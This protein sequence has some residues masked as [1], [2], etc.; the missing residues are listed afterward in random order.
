MMLVEPDDVLSAGDIV[1]NGRIPFMG[2]ADVDTENWLRSLQTVTDLKPRFI[3][4]GH[5]RPSTDTG[6][7]IVFTRG[8]ITYLRMRMAKAVQDWADFDTAYRKADWSKY[9]SLPAFN[10][11]N[12]GNAYR[13]FLDMENAAFSPATPAKP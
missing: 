10:A 8:Y 11:T 6:A 5:G 13:V 12:R 9:S 1:Q 3:I 7:A 2:S 4:P